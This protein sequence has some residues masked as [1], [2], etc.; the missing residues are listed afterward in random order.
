MT[1]SHHSIYIGTLRAWHGRKHGNGAW[2]LQRQPGDAHMYE[3][4]EDRCHASHTVPASYTQDRYQP[5]P[6]LPPKRLTVRPAPSYVSSSLDVCCIDPANSLTI[7][8]VY[9]MLPRVISLRVS[10]FSAR[11]GRL[12]RMQM[13]KSLPRTAGRTSAHRAQMHKKQRDTSANSWHGST[14]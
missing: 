1:H 5:D 10:V 4:I 2:N 13:H 6:F 8:S 7:Q 3:E 14:A 12:Y 9:A 11:S